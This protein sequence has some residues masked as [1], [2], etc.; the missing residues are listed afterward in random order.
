MH[1]CKNIWLESKMI[2]KNYFEMNN[3]HRK[4][5]NN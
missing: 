5:L 2:E 3:D 1:I 4:K